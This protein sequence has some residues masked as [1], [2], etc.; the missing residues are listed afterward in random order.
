M[1]EIA[2]E[3]PPEEQKEEEEVKA[4]VP[5][6]KAKTARRAPTVAKVPVRVRAEPVVARSEPKRRAAPKKTVRIEPPA[7]EPVWDIRH[8]SLNEIRDDDMLGR[9]L[10]R[11]KLEAKEK[12]LELYRRFLPPPK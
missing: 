1:A 3:E 12:R 5:L 6:P 7:P 2:D 10:E 8:V 11:K 4:T 9:Y